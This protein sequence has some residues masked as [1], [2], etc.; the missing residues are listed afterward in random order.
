MAGREVWQQAAHM[1][2]R[3]EAESLHIEPRAGGRSNKPEV[4]EG[5]LLI[6]KPAPS[7]IVP[8]ATQLYMNLATSGTD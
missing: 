6:V 1:L 5:F 8:L 4:A 7:D 3:G 2:E